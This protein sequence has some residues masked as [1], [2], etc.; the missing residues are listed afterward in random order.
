MSLVRDTIGLIV[1]IGCGTGFVPV[2]GLMSQRRCS[3]ERIQ[4][5]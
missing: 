5:Q 1:G 4:S 3:L 2:T